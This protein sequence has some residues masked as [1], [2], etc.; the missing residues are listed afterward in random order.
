MW[1]KIQGLNKRIDD[2]KPWVLAKNGDTEK[3][4]ECLNG[5]AQGLLQACCELS[6]FIPATTDKIFAVFSGEVAPPKEPLFPKS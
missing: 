6:P 5:L 2:E 4:S 1:G 3:L